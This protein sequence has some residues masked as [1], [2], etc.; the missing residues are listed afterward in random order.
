MK[1]IDQIY[2]FL[3]PFSFDSCF[4]LLSI[5]PLLPIFYP[6]PLVV[7]VSSLPTSHYQSESDLRAPRKAVG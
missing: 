1:S 6:P 7:L 2:T 3:A 4:L 5:L